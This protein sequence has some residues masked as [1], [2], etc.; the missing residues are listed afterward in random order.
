MSEE[1][2]QEALRLR[3]Q[4]WTLRMIARHLGVGVATFHKNLWERLRG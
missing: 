1:Q 3:R 4:G 2:L